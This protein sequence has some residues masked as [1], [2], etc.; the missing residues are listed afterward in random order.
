MRNRL[1]LVS[2][3]LILLAGCKADEVEITLRTDDILDVS[4]GGSEMV[5]FEAVFST[6]GDLDDEE[7]AQVEALEDILERYV[8]LDDF[9]L[10]KT[11]MGFEVSIEGEI[12]MTS[13]LST[14]D[15]YFVGV[16]PSKIVE[17]AYL[18]QLNTGS[19][20]N[21]MQLEMEDISFMLSPDAFHPTR[22]KIRGDEEFDI[23]APAVQIDGRYHLIWRG[24]TQDRISMTFANGAF[25]EVGAGFLIKP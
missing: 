1:L 7:R 16:S 6:F 13:D 19:N 3:A 15:A 22:F 10:D 21:A 12:A 25:D 24:K 11:D 18:V 14:S 5:E 8:E 20:F 4:E 9:E 23:I 17:G 2:T